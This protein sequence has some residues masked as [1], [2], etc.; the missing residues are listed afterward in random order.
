[1]RG[2][3]R[4][5]GIGAGYEYGSGIG[6]I[7]DRLFQSS[8]TL[9]P[10][11][12]GTSLTAGLKDDPRFGDDMIESVTVEVIRLL[13]LLCKGDPGLVTQIFPV[14]KRFAI[15]KFN[16]HCRVCLSPRASGVPGDAQ[17]PRS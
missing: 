3:E 11:L 13:G 2:V 12:F 9:T 6:R 1:M 8:G 17:F 4:Y 14:V 10:K 16:E 5:D 15:N 7:G